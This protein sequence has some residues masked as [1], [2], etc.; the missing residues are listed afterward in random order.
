MEREPVESSNLESVGYDPTTQVLEV[1]FRANGRVYQYYDVPA[2][3]YDELMEADSH[4]RYFDTNIRDSYHYREVQDRRSDKGARIA[5]RPEFRART[6]W[7]SQHRRL[8]EVYPYGY[9]E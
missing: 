1:E 3:V 9:V 7:H 5:S 8:R 6:T 4:G 2:E